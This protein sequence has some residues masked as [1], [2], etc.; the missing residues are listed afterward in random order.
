MSM[1]TW[2][3]N[4][5]DLVNFALQCRQKSWLNDWKL[6]NLCKMSIR[7]LVQ[8]TNTV[9]LI[10]ALVRRGQCKRCLLATRS[11]ATF[12]ME[13]RTMET[14]QLYY[15]IRGTIW[16][17]NWDGNDV[18]TG[19]RDQEILPKAHFQLIIRGWEAVLFSGGRKDRL[20]LTDTNGMQVIVYRIELI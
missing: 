15:G 6:L 12:S 18:I 3:F 10:S 9:R 13:N 5:S 2:K 11:W 8:A 17:R 4:W 20:R 19:R 16:Q 1:V 14:V 7:W